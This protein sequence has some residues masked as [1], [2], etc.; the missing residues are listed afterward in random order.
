VIGIDVGVTMLMAEN[1]RSN[2]VWN[3]F[4]KNP[5]I[6]AAMAAVGFH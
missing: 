1:H 3:T 2:F 4:M 5:E 6:P